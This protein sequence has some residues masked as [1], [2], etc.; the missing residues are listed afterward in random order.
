MM[1]HE[2]LE[3]IDPEIDSLI[4]NEE[5]RQ[6]YGL[7]LIASENF[8]PVSV[9]QASASILCNKYSEGQ[10][11]QRYYGGNEYIDK[12]ESI[13]KQ[14]AL[15]LFCLDPEVWDVNVQALSGTAANLAVYTGL[16]G[17]GGKIMGMDLASGGHLSHGFQSARRKVSAS[18]MFF[19]SKQ[20]RCKP[21][22]TIDY[23]S[24]ARQVD[25]FDPDLIIC[26]GSAYPDDFDY[27][28]F[29]EIAQDRYLMM[30]MAH[31]SGLIA[32][33]VMNNPFEYCDIVTT[34]THKILRGP[35]GAIIYYRKVIRDVD[36]KTKIDQAVFPGIQGGP[37]NQKIGALAVALKL[38]KTK[39]YMDYAKQ[40]YENAQVLGR[41][42]SNMGYRL[43][44]GGTK[45]HFVLVCLDGI[46]GQEVE[47]ACEVAGIYLNKNCI[48]S[49]SSPLRPSGIRIGTPALTTRG[50]GTDDFVKVSKFIDE[51]IKIAI[52][53]AKQT[54]R[55][56]GMRFLDYD[57]FKVNIESD[58]RLAD[59]KQRIRDFMSGFKMPI[60]NYRG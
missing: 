3:K 41:E 25:E 49:D 48:L 10:V 40:V 39:E 42:L 12:I 9:L 44:T 7:Q 5:D 43:V 14:R 35:R 28:R 17:S 45:C 8:A 19:E 37:H 24:L 6:C 15:E 34:T 38:A 33:G 31:I 4:K 51:V 47:K 30:D 54:V 59:I 57:A 11:G 20:Y 21:D 32:A 55:S 60:F 23:D 1:I 46:G 50:F 58:A 22:G 53:V 36:V 29:R 56:P 13:C 27:K 26:G 16:V 52:D 18:S 2:R